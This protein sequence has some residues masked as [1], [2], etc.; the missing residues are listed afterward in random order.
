MVSFQM[1]LDSRLGSHAPSEPQ[2]TSIT[3]LGLP[4]IRDSQ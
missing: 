3:D 2:Q 4:T 1:P